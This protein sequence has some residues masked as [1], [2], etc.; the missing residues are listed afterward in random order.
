MTADSLAVAS[1]A[2]A[3]AL[4]LPIVVDFARTGLVARLPTAVLA[5][6][7]VVIA[8]VELAVGLILDAV[9]RGRIEAKRLAYLQAH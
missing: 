2:I 1:A 8:L 6:G 7:L 9:A 3:L 5:T 4:G